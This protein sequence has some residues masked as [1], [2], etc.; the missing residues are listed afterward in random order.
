MCSGNY[1]IGPLVEVAKRPGYIIL[2]YQVRYRVYI[3][4]VVKNVLI[5]VFDACAIN[6]KSSMSSKT[7]KHFRYKSHELFGNSPVMITVKSF[8]K[9]RSMQ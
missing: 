4:P 8:L 3:F 5:D 2:L 1:F 6:V 7:T 9:C